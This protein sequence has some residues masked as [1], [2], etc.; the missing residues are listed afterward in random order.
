LS[1]RCDRG[2]ARG[3][4]GYVGRSDGWQ[5]FY[6][7][8]EMTWTYDRAENGNVALIGE[9][10]EPEGVLALGFSATPEGTETLSRAS[11]AEG[12]QCIRDRVEDA[13]NTWGKQL[14]CPKR[15][16]RNVRPLMYRSAMVL[17]VCE[18]RHYP[19][20]V[21][22]SLSIPWGFS[23]N[24]LGGYHL[25]WPRDAVQTGFAMLAARHYEEA[26]RMA[27]YLIATQH[28]DGRWSQNYYPDG[29]PYWTNIQL[30][31]IGFPILLLAKLKESGHL[32]ELLCVEEMVRKAAGFLVRTGPVS[33]QDR[34]EENS[35]LSPFT[36]AVEIAALVA[37]APFL[38]NRHERKY[39]LSYA[40]YLNR[41]IED[42]MYVAG[43]ALAAKHGV[44]GHYVRLATPEIFHGRHG[45]I[46]IANRQGWHKPVEEVVSLDYLYLSR[47]GLRRPDSE[48]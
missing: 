23:R 29:R 32:G 27:A 38:P 41:R 37:A 25:V 26:R 15:A 14:K 7:H 46:R 17:K 35:G 33:P 6:Q 36:V 20:A 19:G 28:A 1:L 21:V 24:D 4:V 42:W 40:D 48:W 16:K 22:A 8:G 30:D 44:D 3:S 18:D 13:W 9:L 11:L 47:L 43:T 2:F 34:W 10:A 12:F 5:D 31:E 45:E 39:A